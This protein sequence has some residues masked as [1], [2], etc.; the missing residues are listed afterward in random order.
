MSKTTKEIIIEYNGNYNDSFCKKPND[1]W[2]SQEEYV[3]LS[4]LFE[5]LK[6]SHSELSEKIVKLREQH[7]SEVDNEN[8]MTQRL[9]SV[10]HKEILE[11]LRKELHIFNNEMKRHLIEPSFCFKCKM[12]IWVS[13]KDMCYQCFIDSVFAK[14]GF[15]DELVGHLPDQL[16]GNDVTEGER[17]S[18]PNIISEKKAVEMLKLAEVFVNID[19]DVIELCLSLY[20]KDESKLLSMADLVKGV[21]DIKNKLKSLQ[22]CS[23]DNRVDDSK[24][25]DEAQQYGQDTLCVLCNHPKSFHLHNDCCGSEDTCNCKQFRKKV[26][27]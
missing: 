13:F 19:D 2:F 26:K 7:Q 18:K 3:D 27:K 15:E 10:K 21:Q 24:T 1:L 12:M 25:I 8:V 17:P 5:I 4:D 9:C 11:Q 22:S 20:P 6:L 14:Y 16:Q 23:E